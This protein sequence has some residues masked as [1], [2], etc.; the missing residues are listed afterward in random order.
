MMERNTSQRR[1]IRRA[2]EVADR[3]IGPA[4]ALE[5]AQPS[6]PG[7]GIATVYR[8][9][10][11]LVEEAWLVPV[12][13]PGEPPRYELSRKTHHHHFHCRS[14]GRVFDI[15]GCPGDL[16]SITPPGYKV[17][18]HEVVLYGKCPSCAAG[19]KRRT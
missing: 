13:L 16:K 3:P 9:I 18:D 2:F 10:K 11:S 6:A 4:E 5:A 14:C 19:K 7:L 15:K 12:A 8:T 1:A 17:E